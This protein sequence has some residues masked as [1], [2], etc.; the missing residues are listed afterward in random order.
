MAVAEEA[1]LFAFLSEEL[2]PSRSRLAAR[3]ALAA[4]LCLLALIVAAAVVIPTLLVADKRQALESDLDQRLRGYRSKKLL[5]CPRKQS[6]IWI[7]CK[8]PGG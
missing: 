7:E 3:R 6:L 8:N 2:P 5:D 1:D 4:G